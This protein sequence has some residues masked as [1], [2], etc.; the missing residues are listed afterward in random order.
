MNPYTIII[1]ENNLIS[2]SFTY[3]EKHNAI[4]QLKDIISDYYNDDNLDST[5]VIFNTFEFLLYINICH[6]DKSNITLV[7]SGF[8]LSE[9]KE[10]FQEVMYKS[11]DNKSDNFILI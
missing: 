3:K 4:E 11:N 6:F 2:K 10:I 8:T 9:N 5:F 7:L 1:L